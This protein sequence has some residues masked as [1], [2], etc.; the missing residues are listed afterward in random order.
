MDGDGED[1][2]EKSVLIPGGFDADGAMISLDLHNHNYALFVFYQLY[3]VHRC[4]VGAWRIQSSAVRPYQ[5]SEICDRHCAQCVVE[6][7]IRMVSVIVCE[8]G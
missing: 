7:E 6:L 3:T 5:I 4:Q 1:V 8:V 2:R